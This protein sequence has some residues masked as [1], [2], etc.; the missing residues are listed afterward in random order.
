MLGV[1]GVDG[2]CIVDIGWEVGRLGSTE[3]N[4][5]GKRSQLA[6][7]VVFHRMLRRALEAVGKTLLRSSGV[8]V[9]P[10]QSTSNSRPAPPLELALEGSCRLK[11]MLGSSGTTAVQRSF[12]YAGT[13]RSCEGGCY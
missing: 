5:K 1:R 4:E 10:T 3:W 11:E 6:G 2:R 9:I 12:M 8:N 13:K 7:L